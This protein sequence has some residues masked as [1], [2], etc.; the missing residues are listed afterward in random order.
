[1][2]SGHF[3]FHFIISKRTF[4]NPKKDSLTNL[5]SINGSVTELQI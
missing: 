4:Y 3:N 5:F 1:M 2:L